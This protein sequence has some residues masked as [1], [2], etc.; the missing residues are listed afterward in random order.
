MNRLELLAVNVAKMMAL[1]TV[2]AW[3]ISGATNALDEPTK[4]VLLVGGINAVLGAPAHFFA[5]VATEAVKNPQ[6]GE[7]QFLLVAALLIGGLTAAL[8]KGN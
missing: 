1:E 3:L 7:T 8:N 2:G 6:G 4:G 5:R